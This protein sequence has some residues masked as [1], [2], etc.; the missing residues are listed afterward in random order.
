[1][2][3]VHS[4]IE[5]GLITREKAE[6]GNSYRY[7]AT[8]SARPEKPKAT[9]TYTNPYREVS[10]VYESQPSDISDEEIRAFYERYR[11]E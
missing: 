7:K 9:V 10:P 4:L 1:M 5:K 6:Y 8:I 2:D 3:S 11:K